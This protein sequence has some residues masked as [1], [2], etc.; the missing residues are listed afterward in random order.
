[1][2][3]IYIVVI[4]WCVINS[5]LY[6]QEQEKDKL[7]PKIRTVEYM[8]STSLADLELF[9]RE[10][11]LGPIHMIENETNGRKCIVFQVFPFS[12]VRSSKIFVYIERDDR[13]LVFRCAIILFT[14][15]KVKLESDS[16]S[17]ILKY[18]GKEALRIYSNI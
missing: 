18:D 11:S 10:K 7:M 12:G 16:N 4:M 5:K 8:I 3:Y 9:Y 2:K 13:V 14:V 17:W 6:C 1:M 15:D